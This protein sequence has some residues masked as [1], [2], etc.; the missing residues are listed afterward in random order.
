MNRMDIKAIPF[1]MAHLDI[2]APR[3]DDV[4]RYGEISS[5]MVHPMAELSVAWS[6][7]YDGRILFCGGI[8]QCSEKTAHCWT[9]I[10]KY[11]EE[12]PIPVARSIKDQLEAVMNDMGLHRVETANIIDALNHH[13]WCKLLGFHE[14]GEMPYY[15]DQ[16][17]TYIRFA[18]YMKGQ[19]NGT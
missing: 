4:K 19:D 6:G 14:E 7:V 10:S 2:I 9:L 18:K 1:D 13:K 15:D 17:R 8:F 5:T 16:G 11:A 12:F 3:D